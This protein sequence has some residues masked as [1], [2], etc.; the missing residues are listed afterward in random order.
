M[1]LWVVIVLG[2]VLT[3]LTRLSFIVLFGQRQFPAW[4]SRGLRYVP[5]AVLS[6]IIFPELLMPGGTLNIGWGNLRLFAGLA[7]A[8]VAWRTRNVLLTI[9]VGMGV[10]YLLQALA[11]SLTGP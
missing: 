5:P 2:G 10:L 9:A 11:A 7:A 3:Y 6:A 4:L 8:L 1:N